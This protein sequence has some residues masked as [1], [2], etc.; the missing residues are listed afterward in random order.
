MLD[1]LREAQRKRYAVG[2]FESWNLESLRAVIEAA[3]EERSPVIVGFSGS[4]LANRGHRLEPYAAIGKIAVKTAAIPAALL[5]N[6]ASSFRQIIDGLRLGFTSLMMDTSSLPYEKNVQ[7]TKK[8]VEA[9]HAEGA[10]VEAQLDELPCARDGVLPGG[11]RE[12]SLTDPE[13]AAE[14][15]KKT[16]V[17]ALAVSVGNVHGLYRAKAKIDFNRLKRLKER[18]ETPLVLHG[19][20]GVSDD[21]A[22]R[23]IQLGICKVNVGAALRSAFISGMK[24]SLEVGSKMDPEEVLESAVRELK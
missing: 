5:L 3:E 22:R 14:F 24:R 7:L 9:A 11:V 21:S 16:G 4:I 10:C 1:M 2:Y 12:T 8:I 17:D 13:R 19:A 15:V 6:E 23:A 18:I 20:T